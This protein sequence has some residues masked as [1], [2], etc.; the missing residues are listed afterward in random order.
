MHDEFRIGR[1]LGALRKEQGNWTVETLAG[2]LGLEKERVEAWEAGAERPT[3]AQMEA[4][5]RVLEVRHGDLIRRM[6]RLELEDL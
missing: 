2:A 4:A 6:E 1:A 5:L 3:V